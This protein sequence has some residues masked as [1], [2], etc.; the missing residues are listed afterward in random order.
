MGENRRKKDR[1]RWEKRKLSRWGWKV[2]MYFH[3]VYIF[4]YTRAERKTANSVLQWD[5]ECENKW[6]TVKTSGWKRDRRW[7][8]SMSTV[9]GIFSKP[10]KCL[11]ARLSMERGARSE[12]G[13]RNE[14]VGVKFISLLIFSTLSHLNLTNTDS[15]LVRKVF[16]F[17]YQKKKPKWS[18]FPFPAADHK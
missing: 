12:V 6:T 8:D 13:D 17:R 11:P 10:S 2:F 5:S 16:P 4:L 1:A 7:S 18:P 14:K 15:A 9:N 3:V